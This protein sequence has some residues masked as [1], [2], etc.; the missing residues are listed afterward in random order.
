MVQHSEINIDLALLGREIEELH[1]VYGILS[2]SSSTRCS[3]R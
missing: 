3:T 1:V 2:K